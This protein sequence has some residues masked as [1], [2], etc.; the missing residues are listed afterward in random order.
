LNKLSGGLPSNLSSNLVTVNFAD[1]YLTGSIPDSYGS[2]QQL[3]ALQLANNFLNGTI[4]AS[5]GSGKSFSNNSNNLLVD[6]QNNSL[7]GLDTELLFEATRSTTNINVWLAGN[8]ELCSILAI[9]VNLKVCTSYD[10]I[11]VLQNNTSSSNSQTSTCHSCSLPSMPVVDVASQVCRCAQPIPVVIRL[12]SPGFSFF[13]RFTQNLTSLLEGALI[14]VSQVQI[15]SSYWDA[16]GERLT[17]NL[18]LFPPNSTFNSS[19]VN[20][21]AFIFST[22]ILSNSSN[23]SLSV[24]GPYDLLNFNNTG[25]FSFSSSFLLSHN[26]PIKWFCSN[27]C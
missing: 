10:G 11:K 21:L 23:W 19:E 12:K 25:W 6:L 5:L 20:N 9:T 27:N 7:T 8:Q 24:V 13:D 22:F 18:L 4:P 2:L 1:N 26:L 17:L 14:S 3:Q 15:Q 16:A